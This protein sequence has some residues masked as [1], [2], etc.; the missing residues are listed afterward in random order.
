MRT[1][2]L[3]AATSTLAAAAL[4]VGAGTATAEEVDQPETTD[5]QVCVVIETFGS[6]RTM[7]LFPQMPES[8][9]SFGYGSAGSGS[10]LDLLTGVINTGSTVLSVD[11]PNSTGSYAPG[12]FGS[13]GPEASIG[14]IF[15]GSI[16]SLGGAF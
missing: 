6:P 5:E 8:T 7:C 3:A 10:L 4:L 12:S 2:T 16:G 13:Y 11:I 1:T 14:Q 15:T 9:G